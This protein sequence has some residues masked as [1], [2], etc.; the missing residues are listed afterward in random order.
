MSYTLRLAKAEEKE[1]SKVKNSLGEKTASG[2]IRLL[3]LMYLEDQGTL[4]ELSF[5]VDETGKKLE[6]IK[7]MLNQKEKLKLALIDVSKD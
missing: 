4:K 5:Q 6:K 7:S 3:I 1:L 2:A